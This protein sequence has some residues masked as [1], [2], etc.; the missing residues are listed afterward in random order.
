MHSYH[1]DEGS[2][3]ES[4]SLF[5]TTLAFL[6]VFDEP[7]WHEL[8]DDLPLLALQQA[9]KDYH[10]ITVELTLHQTCL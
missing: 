2:S 4:D 5:S 1:G 9:V 3:W 8:D 7:S 10:I 6:V